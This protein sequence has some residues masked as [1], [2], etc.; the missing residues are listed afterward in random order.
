MDYYIDTLI[1]SYT[2]YIVHRSD[3]QYLPNKS[4]RIFLGNFSD[5]SLAI[6]KAREYSY[7]KA[8]G[9]YWCCRSIHRKY[10]D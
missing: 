9:C 7:L 3:C 5:S 8:N 10:N 4:N 6:K 1:D 2:F